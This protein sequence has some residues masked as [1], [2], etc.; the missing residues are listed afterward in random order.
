MDTFSFVVSDGIGYSD[1]AAVTIVVDSSPTANDQTVD[2]EHDLP[3]TIQLTGDDPDDDADPGVQPLTYSLVSQP[4]HGTLTGTAPNLVYTPQA[5]YN[6][7]DS[8]TFTISDGILT[9]NVG[10]VNL[11]IDETA[12]SVVDS[13]SSVA[14]VAG[15]PASFSASADGFPSPTVQWQDSTD[16]GSTWNDIAGATSTT[17]ITP[18]TALTDSGELFQA[19][20]TNAMGSITTSTAT[21]TVVPALTAS[22]TPA[23]TFTNTAV[24]TIDVVFST[25]INTGSLSPGALTLT[26]NGGANL[27]DAGVSLSLVSGDTYAIGG[28]SSLT[29]AE[30]NYELTVNA[31]DLEDQY[32]F[33]G[34]GTASTLWLMDTTTPSSSVSSLLS[35]TTSTSFTVAVTGT[36]PSGASGSTPSGIATFAVYVSTNNGLY[37]LWNTLTPA[38][39][40][41]QYV[42]QPGSTYAFYSIATDNA[43]NVQPTPAAAQQTVQ[44]VSPLSVSS[45]TAVSPNPRLTPVSIID[46]TFNVPIDTGSVAAGAVSLTDNGNPVALSGLTFT[47]VKGSISRY[48]V[49]DLSAFTDAAGAYTLTVDASG[50]EDQ[51]GN[52]GIGSLATSWVLSQSTPTISWANPAN[53]VYGTAL[54]GT[55]LDATASVPGTFTYTPAAG[56]VLAPATTRRSRS[57]LYRQ[58]RRITPQPLRPRRSTSCKQPRPLV[59]RTRQTSS[60]ARRCSGTQLDATANVVGNFTYTPNSGT[61]LHAGTGQTLSASFVPTD[62]TDYTTASA[63]ATINVLQATPTITWTNPANIVYGTALSGTQLDATASVAGNFTYT[64]NAGTVL[65]AGTGQALSASFVPTD[66]TD[67]TAASATAT[68]NVLQATPTITWANPANIV[69][70]TALSGTQLDATASVAGNFTYSPSAGTVLHAG[71]GQTLSASFVP[72]DST[73]YTAASATTAINVLQATP[74]VTWANP[75]NIVYGTALSGTQLDATTS[76]AGNFTYSPSA[77][78]V[79]HAGT[80]Q[81]LSASF[82]P[83]DSTDYTTAS[84]NATINVLQATPTVTWAN[85]ANIVY[86]TALSGTQLDATASVAGNF[87]YSPSAGTVLHAGTGQTLSASFVPTDS[88]DYTTASANATINVL[89]ATPT[90][91]WANPANIVYGAALSGTQ[92]DATASVAGNFTY[93]PSAGTVLHAGTGQALSAS[94]VPTD[95]TDYTTV[96]T[97]ATIN[98]LQATPTIS[99]ANPANIVYGTA[100]SG[101]QLDATASVAGNF[102]Y[103]P[104]AGTVLHAGTGQTLSASFVPTD[105]TDY[106]TASANATINVLQATPSI[107]WANPAA[108]PSG[109]P[110]GSTQLDATAS[111]AVGGVLGSVAGTFSYNPPA[112]TVLNAA[113]SRT[114]SV[115]F[116]PTD[117]TDY[118]TAAGSATIQIFSALSILSIAAISPNPRNT[119]VSSIDVTF[120]EPVK[121][122]TFTDSALTLTDNGSANL[123]TNAVTTSL[124]SGSTYQLSGFTGLTGNNGD[125]TLTVSAADIQDQYGFAGA[126]TAGT[127]WLMDTSPPASHVSALPKTET[128]L[129]FAVSVTG[130]DAGSPPSGLA[131]FD[132]YSSTNGGAWKF[133]TNVPASSPSATFSGQSSTTYGFYSIAH[134]LAGNTENKKPT[135]EANTALPNLT[136]PVTSVDGTTGTNPSTVSTAGTF[137][138]NV[139]GS[140]PGGSLL[141]YFE[142]FVSID[143]GAYQEVGPYAIPA[144]AADRSGKYHS[145]M[146]YQGLTDGNTH[147][148]AFYS[149]GLDAAGN[150]Q[151]APSSPNLTLSEK[152]TALTGSNKLQ[153][154]GFTVEHDSPSRSYIRYLDIGFNESDAQS[155]SALQSMANSISGATPAIQIFKYDLNNDAS[156]KTAVPPSGVSVDVIDHAI[157][158][159]FGANGIGG[160]PQTNAADGY[161]EVDIQL[162][163][164]QTSVH[165]FYRLLGD[166]NG[167]QVVDQN[168]LN[169]IAADV[170]AASQMGWT[171]LSADVTGAGTVTTLDLTIATRAKGHPLAKKLS[172][173]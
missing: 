90:V 63:N 129:T 142:V 146:L 157:E 16:G 70:G 98:V 173:G 58:T 97:N 138:L 95:S 121:L 140:D 47:L 43:G 87:T 123:I 118:T 23:P 172:L 133:W 28:L 14:V 77:G 136:A 76:V 27:I 78:T 170:G 24:S 54:S 127:S 125:Y 152:I 156:S 128:S 18:A 102:T 9:S 159:D 44:I 46:V 5:G 75:A 86:G 101:T 99:W 21:L 60:T 154:T 35:P 106:T 26:N 107:T 126:G 132:I 139:T 84:A 10:T 6:G 72:T 7:S 160:H 22:V 93:T 155:G 94:F 116:T 12:P 114:L 171:P 108:I 38:D 134:D 124:I 80:G 20:F 41:A 17:Y 33:A 66:S 65:H 57:A 115:A 96:S 3:Q 130:F 91:T 79:L 110:L 82:V 68:I 92:L 1:P 49:G 11:Q 164:G 145:T 163:N 53:I 153:V 51:Y 59:G 88:T 119:A 148:Y 137:T 166:V 105:S 50:L 30:G 42:G 120:T 117:T 113:N 149:A 162:P 109:T 32:G 69:Y 112:G 167:D 29:T 150:M 74:T 34:T 131:S 100:L 151:S 147:S 52:V 67:Y 135:I 158:L 122:S 103:T 143:G 161:Y 31:A 56:A 48:E 37:A 168:D 4:T 89:Q 55:Q 71:T 40:S 13:P 2:V 73:D 111:W 144:G 25:P 61:V 141:N 8:F 19:V 81:T 165:H 169:E 45:I 62:S 39:P 104:S 85:P 15:S 36:D 83:T 64:P